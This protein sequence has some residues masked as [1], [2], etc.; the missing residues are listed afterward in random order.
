MEHLNLDSPLRL[1]QSQMI[2]EY[3]RL[4]IKTNHCVEYGGALRRI[5]EASLVYITYSRQARLTG[6]ILSHKNKTQR[7]TTC[8]S[9]LDV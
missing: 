6:S 8:T 9:I 2:L 7:I 1:T 4:T 3:V 5:S